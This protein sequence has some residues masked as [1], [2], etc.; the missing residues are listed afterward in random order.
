[1]IFRK[2]TLAVAAAAVLWATASVAAMTSG[3]LV[4]W[5]DY[6]H[7]NFGIP[8]TFAVHTSSTIAGP[9][10]TWDMDLNALTA[11]L[12]FWLI[13]MIAIVLAGLARNPKVATMASQGA[14]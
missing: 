12:A 11:D 14:N 7:T 3:A 5:P 9:V 10:D 6:V 1:V 2:L 8:F 13:G 4:N